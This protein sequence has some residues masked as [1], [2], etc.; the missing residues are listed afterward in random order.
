MKERNLNPVTSISEM[1]RARIFNTLLKVKLQAMAIQFASLPE[2]T[3]INMSF[4]LPFI[5][6]I[7]TGQNLK[8]WDHC[9]WK[10]LEKRKG[11]QRKEEKK[12]VK[13]VEK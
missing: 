5:L 7:E 6:Y 11:R 2:M 3:Q 10:E 9:I 8:N 13:I 12:N 1:D 4:E